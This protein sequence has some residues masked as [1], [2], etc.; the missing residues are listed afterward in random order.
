MNRTYDICCE[1]NIINVICGALRCALCITLIDSIDNVLV[2]WSR[3]E[4]TV[5]GEE[6]VPF[7]EREKLIAW[8]FSGPVN[9]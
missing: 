9:C 6:Y 3:V 4:L 1:N 7:T 2:F 8:L 5:C